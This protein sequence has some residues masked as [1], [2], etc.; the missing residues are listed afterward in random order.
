[1]VT[2]LYCVIENVEFTDFQKLRQS[3]FFFLL[4]I[5]NLFILQ[6]LRFNNLIGS[7]NWVIDQR[8][9]ALTRVWFTKIDFL[10]R[11]LNLDH[12]K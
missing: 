2:E 10:S 4:I 12:I 9:I 1:M 7:T 5:N 8:A 3:N 6:P 11:I